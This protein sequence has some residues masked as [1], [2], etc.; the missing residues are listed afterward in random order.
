MLSFRKKILVT[1]FL[2]FLLVIGLLLPFARRTVKDI[3]FVAMDERANEL[4]QRIRD[5]P[6]DADLV[7]GLK[8][9]KSIIFF[10]V[11]VITDEKKVIYDS[12]VKRVLGEAFDPEFIVN[13]PEVNMAFEKG[14]GYSE[15]YSKILDQDF[16]YF[17]KSFNFHGKIYV[18]RI[19]FPLK[20]VEEIT[21]DFEIG[22]FGSALFV[23]ILFSTM[24]WFVINYLTRPI[25]QINTAI[26][27]YQEG[28]TKTVPEITLSP[29][30]R[31]DE[32]G[33]LADTLNSL[34]VK[35]REHISSLMIEKN[36][37]KAILESLVEGVIALDKNLV[38]EYANTMAIKL[39]QT[40]SRDLRDQ[41][42]TPEIQE[43]C[44]S[45][46]KK[47]LNEN[48]TIT[49]MLELKRKGEKTYLNVVATPT[50]EGTGVILVLQDTTEHYKLIEMRKDFIA[51]A[52]HE[53]KTPITII[54]G[55]AEAL[56]D[57][58]EL[59]RN[60]TEEITGKIVKNCERMTVLIKDL[61]TITDIERIPENRLFECD[62]EGI[63]ENAVATIH[64]AFPDAKIQI[65]RL[66]D[67]E[68]HLLA[69]PNLLDLAITNLLTNA[70]NYSNPPADVTVILE[71]DSG[72]LKLSVEDKGLGIPEKDLD[73]IFQRFYQVDKARSKKVG[74]S[75]LGLSIVEMIV[76]KHFGRIDVK[77]ELG[78]GTTFT[79]I[80]PSQKSH[81]I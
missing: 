27:P 24:T 6:D 71:E 48:M 66:S 38:I 78:K 4:I 41:P 22:I 53:L 70:I 7:T 59:D 31:S 13:H 67:H 42:F 21:K 46:L 63:V 74:G 76:T 80:L 73:N 19:A 50:G 58:P 3:A 1:F 75:G 36:E 54:R 2:V 49:Q 51:N 10:R 64:D 61:L 69:D 23:L 11:A 79:L 55:F 65:R 29:K 5:E 45:I 28:L 57:N 43:Q 77:S 68:L 40:K 37:K 72:F 62:L 44:Y 18:L 35:I 16:A 81:R 8:E 56:H 52:S 12:H 20:Y 17:A 14:A 60:I 15:E 33:K 32:F 25:Q 39:L 30:G 9:Q 47:S 34:S 26:L